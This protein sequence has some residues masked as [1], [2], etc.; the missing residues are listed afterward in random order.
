MKPWRLKIKHWWVCRPGVADSRHLNE[1]QDLDPGP[2]L[3]EKIDPDP[4]ESD[5]DPLQCSFM[6]IWVV[7]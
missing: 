6:R 2:Y 1:K 4:Q 7:F 5:A 3:D